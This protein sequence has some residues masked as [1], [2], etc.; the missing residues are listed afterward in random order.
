MANS[1]IK[2]ISI[3]MHKKYIKNIVKYGLKEDIG[4]GDITSNLIINKKQNISF[5]VIAKSDMVLCGLDFFKETLLSLNKKIIIK[6][7]YEDGA[8]IK[9]NTIFISGSGNA[10]AILAGERVAL[11]LMQYL[12]AISTQT[13]IFVNIVKP[14]NVEILDTRKILP[15]YRL[16]AK[17]AV[18]IG[19]GRNH[20][21]CLDD[22]ILI[23]DNHIISAGSVTQALKKCKKSALIK[24]IECENLSQV[25]EAIKSKPHIIMLDNM[26]VSTIKEA[27]SIINK[28]SKIEVSG[29]ISL[30]NIQ[31]IAQTG[32]DFISIGEITHSVKAVDISLNLNLS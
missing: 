10:K 15:F 17:Y 18:R 9:K 12:S 20:R 16:A 11:N 23:K 31:E 29:N 14:Y 7:A 21:I 28:R 26:S 4:S 30:K 6:S 2:T 5:E 1:Q 19:G 25:K 24:E 13:N 3:K 8:H 32:V 27:V 22:Q